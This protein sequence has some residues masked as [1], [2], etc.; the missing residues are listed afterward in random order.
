MSSPLLNPMVS[1][2]P[3]I[4]VRTG[5]GSGR[6]RLAAFDAALRAAGVGDYNLVTLSSVIPD[7]SEVVRKDD[8]LGGAHGDR[9]W[10]VLSSA[11]A[12]QHGEIAWAGLGW[13]VDD[14]GRGLFVEHHGGS[15][16]SL[17]EQIRLSLEDM[18][19]GRG[20]GFDRIES[21]T[22]SAHCVSDPVCAVAVAAYEVQGWGDDD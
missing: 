20:G 12:D 17:L 6:T 9:L 3:L 14:R 22:V 4:T 19:Q 21:E 5:S 7:G 2:A 13:A 16:R 8:P 11:I 1:G 15:E 18:S 10:C